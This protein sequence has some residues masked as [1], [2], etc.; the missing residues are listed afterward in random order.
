MPAF[1]SQIITTLEEAVPHV[2]KGVTETIHVEDF[3]T[4][5]G[6]PKY[7]GCFVR[8]RTDGVNVSALDT[9][10]LTHNTAW[11]QVETVGATNY[12][13][14]CFGFIDSYP[15]KINDVDGGGV[16]GRITIHELN[17]GKPVLVAFRYLN[18]EAIAQVPNFEVGR[19]FWIYGL[20]VEIKGVVY[21]V[22]VVSEVT[23]AG[24]PSFSMVDILRP[25]PLVK[26]MPTHPR[27][28]GWVVLALDAGFLVDGVTPP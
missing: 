11:H 21:T 2:V 22:P 6:V 18:S 27:D 12:S 23:V 17:V 1:S 25:L 26:N 16:R 10:N 20:D 14:K 3:N 4:I 9:I 13:N 5:T 19:K 15:E 28:Y 24:E 7:R 8:W